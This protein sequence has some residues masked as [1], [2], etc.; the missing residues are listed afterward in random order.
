MA[1]AEFWVD[2]DLNGQLTLLWFLNWIDR[3]GLNPANLHLVHGDRNWGEIDMTGVTFMPP[4]AQQVGS[5]M[6]ALARQA[7]LRS[8][9]QPRSAGWALL[10]DDLSLLPFLHRTVA[11][12]LDELPDPITG[13]A[14]SEWQVL[15]MI[16]SGGV[17]P[18]DL[19]IGFARLEPRALSYWEV[20]KL[21][22]MFAEHSDPA[23]LGLRAGPFD[24]GLHRNESLKQ[25]YDSSHL[26]LSEFGKALLDGQADFTTR[27]RINRWWGGTHLTNEN[28]WRWDGEQ[29]TLIPPV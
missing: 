12:M 16:A 18:N 19:Q 23:I 2:P 6:L 13:L 26:T 5:E 10:D 7:W 3:Q 22:D 15:A 21:L 4:A 29:R 1:R 11:K 28:C 8:E 14:I 17:R 25:C 24:I 20:G 27:G 9:L